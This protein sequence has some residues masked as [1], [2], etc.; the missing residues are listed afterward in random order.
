MQQCREASELKM[1]IFHQNKKEKKISKKE[2][3]KKS[4]CQKPLVGGGGDHS[5]LEE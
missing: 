1:H 4:W 3:Y 5:C 2:R